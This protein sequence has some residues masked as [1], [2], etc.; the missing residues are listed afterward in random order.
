VTGLEGYAATVTMAQV[1]N[2]FAG[3]GGFNAPANDAV[4]QISVTVTAP[5]GSA[6]TLSG[7]RFRY[8]PT[9]TP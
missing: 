9:T 8:A 2:D 6:I 3:A 4:L 1:G 5:D 7:Y